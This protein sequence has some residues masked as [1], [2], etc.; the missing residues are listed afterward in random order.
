MFHIFNA[1]FALHLSHTTNSEC[2][3]YWKNSVQILPLPAG[4]DLVVMMS[5]PRKGCPALVLRGE[6]QLK[7]VLW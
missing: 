5:I 6:T 1:T 4:F 7:S 2:Q 3:I